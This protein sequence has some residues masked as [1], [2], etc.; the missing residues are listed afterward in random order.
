MNILPS[1]RGGIRA[2]SQVPGG[3]AAQ[4]LKVK[5]GVW[6]WNAPCWGFPFS[7]SFTFSLTT[8]VE[9]SCLDTD[10]AAPV[11]TATGCSVSRKTNQRLHGSQLQSPPTRQDSASSQTQRM[12]V[13]RPR[14]L[15]LLLSGV[16]VLTETRAGECGVW[17]ERPLRGGARG[18]PGSL[19]A[20]PQGESD[21]TPLP[22][23][24]PSPRSRPV[25]PLHPDP[26]F[27]P[28]PEIRPVL[29]LFHLTGPTSP[30][31]SRPPHLGP[32]TRAGRRVELSLTPSRPQAS[33]R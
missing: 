14:T 15:L 19:G 17:K 3:R 30:P 4:D 22:R 24:A 6:G 5:G 8:C 25:H 13:M 12:R 21:P 9:P 2:K 18:P 10:D 32:G 28:P 11:L 26:S 20:G 31:P 16:L 23:A 7:P 33:T 27:L 29:D 1:R